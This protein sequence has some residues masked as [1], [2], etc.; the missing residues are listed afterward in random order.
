MSALRDRDL[1][2]RP[3]AQDTGRPVLWALARR[4]VVAPVRPPLLARLTRA[5]LLRE[6]AMIGS[7]RRTDGGDVMA[8]AMDFLA[9]RAELRKRRRRPASAGRGARSPARDGQ[10]QAFLDDVLVALVR[11]YEGSPELAG[12]PA[13]TEP[14]PEPDRARP[15]IAMALRTRSDP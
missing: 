2:D 15:P 7:R 6:A 14:T 12:S 11:G 8:L 5:E 3:A 4:A 13:W 10:V 9:V 1:L